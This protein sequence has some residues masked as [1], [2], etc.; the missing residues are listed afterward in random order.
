MWGFDMRSVMD[1]RKIVL[2][3][4]LA[5]VL[6]PSEAAVQESG[7]RSHP[8]VRAAAPPIG[9]IPLGGILSPLADGTIRVYA[10]TFNQLAEKIE[11]VI[12]NGHYKFEVCVFGLQITCNTI[13]ESDWTVTVTQLSFDISPAR[14]RISGRVAAT[15]CGTNFS[16]VLG[17]DADV[18]AVQNAILVTASR[19]TIQPRFHVSGYEIA[20]PVYLDVAP[21]LTLPPI[22][23]TTGFFV[24]T[25]ARGAQTLHLTP[26]N[27]LLRKGE[28]Y[29]QLQAH[30][31][32][33]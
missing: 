9:H 1:R 27:V 29:I 13:C 15:W 4:L 11:P 8:A 31:S 19:T 23:I 20:L 28:G 30:I 3:V 22:A 6:L 18:S 14:V 25:T 32:L 7:Q 21:S 26:S 5:A 16:G 2:I 17:T 33:W 10:S 24:F 12:F